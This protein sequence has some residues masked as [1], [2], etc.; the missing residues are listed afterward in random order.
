M[1]ESAELWRVS[2]AWERDDVRRDVRPLYDRP[3]DV[4]RDLEAI[5]IVLDG[6]VVGRR[7]G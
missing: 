6:A 1:G 2:R 3:M 7:N 4:L 5:K